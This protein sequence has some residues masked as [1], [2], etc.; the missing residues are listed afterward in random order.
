MG[1][2]ARGEPSQIPAEAGG[3]SRVT[4]RLTIVMY[5]FVRDLAHSRYPRIKGLDEREFEGQIEYIGRHYDVVRMEDVIGAL[6]GRVELPAKP[7]LLTFDD[8]YADH[9][10]TVF[11]LLDRFGMQGSFFPPARAVLERK[12]LD[13]N[14][15]HFVLAVTEDMAELAAVLDGLVEDAREEHGLE[16]VEWYRQQY[17]RPNRF[18]TSEVVYIKRLLQ[19][20]LPESLRGAIIDRLF[21]QFVTTDEAAFATELYVSLEQLRCMHRHGMHIGS[22]G[23]DHYWLNTLSPAEQEDQVLKSLEF[24]RQV[25]VD[26]DDWTMCYPYGGYD[27]S[28]LGV[29]AKHGCRLGLTTEVAVAEL[30][31][32]RRFELARLDTNDLPKVGDAAPNDWTVSA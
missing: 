24:L 26:M 17:A 21:R 30:D 13:V 14:K 29:L 10:R 20:A 32:E 19:H 27:G 11:P 1:G 2:S 8:G 6:D 9:Y 12:V 3:G 5:H 18:D 23:Y 4:R 16:A 25:G 7:Y 22:H 31:P 15:I 28:L